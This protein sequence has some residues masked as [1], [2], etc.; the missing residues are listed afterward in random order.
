LEAAKFKKKFD[1]SG[2]KESGHICTF[3]DFFIGMGEKFTLTIHYLLPV[4]WQ[5]FLN[6]PST[7]AGKV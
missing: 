5:I 1:K 7:L 2:R 4:K 3:S 6:F